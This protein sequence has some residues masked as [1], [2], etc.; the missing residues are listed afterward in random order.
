MKKNRL[1]RTEL[2][3]SQIVLGG[4]WVGG[5]FIDPDLGVMEKALVK[6]IN[7]GINWIDT[8][9]SYSEGQSEKNIGL[10]LSSIKNNNIY[11]SSKARLEPISSETI[12]SQLDRK[13]DESLER[14]NRSYIDLYQLHNRIE[15]VGTNEHFSA[16][17]IIQ[18]K[19]VLDSMEKLKSEGRI[20]NIGITAL[21]NLEPIKEVIS[22]NGFDT[23]QVYYNLLN[24]S[25][26][27]KK[28]DQWDDHDF[29]GIVDQCLK[30]DMGIMCIRIFAAGYLAT[31]IR[32]G[33]EISV[34]QG[35]SET[36]QKRRIEKLFELL[37]NEQGERAQLALRY[38]LSNQSLSCIVTGLSK[39]EHLDQ[40][41]EAESLGPLDE[42]I[43][44][45][46]NFLHKSNFI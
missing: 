9:E 15:K 38:G 33:R 36:E 14:L 37:K 20:K 19:G 29:S 6:A 8:A 22:T 43:I 44:E 34:T 17:E 35:I 2:K 27:F 26:A 32:H 24:P 5:L 39:I 11:I 45:K 7:A 25:S 30:Y 3:V 41:I 16:R 31:D 10:L 23:A 4:G 40:I 21:G 18:R 42:G 46:I 1:G 13:I 12:F 28:K